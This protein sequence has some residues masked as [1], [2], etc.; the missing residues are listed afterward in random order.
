MRLGHVAVVKKVVDART[1]IVDHANWRGPG[2]SGGNVYKEIPVIDVSAHN[3]WS[4]V[5]V[6]LGHSGE[7][8]SSVYPTNGFIYARP[9]NG[10]TTAATPARWLVAQTINHEIR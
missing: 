5:R 7:F 10:T 2:S 3:D 8:G 4:E 6:G 1:V 9:D